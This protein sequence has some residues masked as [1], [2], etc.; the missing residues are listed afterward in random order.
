[1]ARGWANRV[2]LAI[3]YSGGC[4]VRG[5]VIFH[6]SVDSGHRWL[7]QLNDQ[8][9]RIEYSFLISSLTA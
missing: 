2:G 3:D 1:V 7:G 9:H 5:V 6:Y 4:R 8:T